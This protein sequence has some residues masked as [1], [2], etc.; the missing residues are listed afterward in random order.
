MKI[1]M[2]KKM[3]AMKKKEGK[4]QSRK[5]LVQ[6]VTMRMQPQIAHGIGGS[7]R[8]RAVK[9]SDLKYPKR[10]NAGRSA[11]RRRE[12]NPHKAILP[13]ASK[14]HCEKEG[15]GPQMQKRSVREEGK[16]SQ[17]GGE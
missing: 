8:G 7:V 13:R 10:A 17:K 11:Q 9:G 5:C 1:M 14:Q 16:G 3:K 12:K 6:K 2:T 4:K 15:E